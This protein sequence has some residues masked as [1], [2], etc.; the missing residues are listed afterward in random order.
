MDPIHTFPAWHTE[1]PRAAGR[2]KANALDN[3]RLHFWTGA[4][5]LVTDLQILTEKAS[6]VA[7]ETPFVPRKAT[8]VGGWGMTSYSLCPQIRV[9]KTSEERE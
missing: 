9:L 6:T 3:R 1:S 5:C 8:E 7:Q 2:E 4:G